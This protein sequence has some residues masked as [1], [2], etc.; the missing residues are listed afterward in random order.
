MVE[1]PGECKVVGGD[2]TCPDLLVN[3]LRVG[4]YTRLRVAEKSYS[5]RR[6]VIPDLP[7]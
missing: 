2:I 6:P 7:T 3:D 1:A 4:A 5:I